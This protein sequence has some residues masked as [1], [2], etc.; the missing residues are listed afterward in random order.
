MTLDPLVLLAGR[1]APGVWAIDVDDTGRRQL[2]EGGAEVIELDLSDSPDK[3]T[4]LD[5]LAD[6]LD[7]P[8]YFGRNWDAAYDCLTDW[9]NEPGSVRTILVSHSGADDATSK[10][11]ISIFNDAAEF[12]RGRGLSLYVL[13]PE[14]PGQPDLAQW[15]TSGHP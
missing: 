7:F 2:L 4:T 11:L 13:W 1:L 10:A 15:P 9:T 5:R 12:L 6:A 8:D 14:A 3:A